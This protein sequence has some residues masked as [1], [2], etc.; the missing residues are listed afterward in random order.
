[1]LLLAYYSLFR[2]I[3]WVFCYT[4]CTVHF[5]TVGAANVMQSDCLCLPPDSNESLTQPMI[6]EPWLCCAAGKD[7]KCAT[8][9]CTGHDA[10][11]SRLTK[12]KSKSL[13]QVTCNPITLHLS[14]VIQ[15]QWSQ[16]YQQMKC[17]NV[18]VKLQP[19]SSPW[20]E[21][22]D[23]LFCFLKITILILPF[24]HLKILFVFSR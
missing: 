22:H 24:C 9:S 18:S 4:K 5:K 14:Y 13:S 15:Y 17:W 2:P 3:G 1:M 8:V 23:K 6:M 16:Q 19:Q 12:L 10:H 7:P 21:W 11:T 20:F